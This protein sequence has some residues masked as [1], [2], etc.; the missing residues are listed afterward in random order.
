MISFVL[1]ASVALAWC[2]P[3]EGTEAGWKLLERAKSDGAIV[4]SHWALEMSSALLAGE[5]RERIRRDE[6][7][8]F[9]ADLD[10][11]QIEMDTLTHVR[12]CHETLE[13][14]REHGLSSYDA[15]Y[16]ELA[17]RRSIP[18]A[19]RDRRL[20]AAARAAGVETIEP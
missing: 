13:L 11:A 5:R 14:A 12:A 7:T 3:D 8:D 10:T 6:A 18:L 2:F 17:R 19:T 4:P 15:A 9:I 20:A 1:D 16:V